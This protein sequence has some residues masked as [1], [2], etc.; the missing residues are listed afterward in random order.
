MC[1]LSSQSRKCKPS[2]KKHFVLLKNVCCNSY[3]GS[4]LIHFSCVLSHNIRI[5]KQM[6]HRTFIF[7]CILV[8]IHCNHCS[9]SNKKHSK[10]IKTLFVNSE[11]VLSY[12]FSISSSILFSENVS[13]LHLKVDQSCVPGG[14]AQKLSEQTQEKQNKQGIIL[15]HTTM[16][17]GIFRVK[18]NS[19]IS[20]MSLP[21][22]FY[23]L[24]LLVFYLSLFLFSIFKPEDLVSQKLLE[25]N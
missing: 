11:P 15:L 1:D 3:I 12:T 21:T 2:D 10:T 6:M 16:W 13:R 19:R 22:L 18:M 25:K 8:E 14:Y 23:N 24:T 20:E 7:R 5:T 4:Y 17:L 9:F